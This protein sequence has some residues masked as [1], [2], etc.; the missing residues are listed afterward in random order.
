MLKESMRSQNLQSMFF[1]EVHTHDNKLKQ[2]YNNITTAHIITP[3][4]SG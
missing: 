3:A 1:I 2:V 4:L